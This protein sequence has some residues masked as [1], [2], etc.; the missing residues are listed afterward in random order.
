MDWPHDPD[1]EEGSEGMRKYGQAILAK[2]LDEEGD[3]PLSKA[4]FVEE[5]GNEPVRLNHERVVSVEDIFE[6]VE[7]D[8]FEDI[9]AFHKAVGRAMRSAGMWEVELSKGV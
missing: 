8:E 2:K 3:F 4:D 6:H 9:V 1:G 7:E 5:H